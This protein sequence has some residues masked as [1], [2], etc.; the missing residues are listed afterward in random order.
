[1]SHSPKPPFHHSSGPRSAEV[2]L[3][4]EAFGHEEAK[5]GYPFVGASG[6]ELSRMLEEAGIERKRCFLTNVFAFQ[7]HANNLDT[8]CGSKKEV[9]GRDY[10][11]QPL[12]SG[13]YLQPE[14]FGELL[15]LK[16]ELEVV[17]PNLVI[18]LGSTAMW[19]LCS[20]AKISAVRGTVTAASLVPGLKVLPTY[21]PAAVLR[22]WAL[23]PIVVADLI[24]SVNEAKFPEIIR[25]ARFIQINPTFEEVI[26][27]TRWILKAASRVAA[28]V[29]TGNKQ[30]KCVGFAWSKSEALVVPFVDLA[31]PCGSYWP[32]P[33]EELLVWSC[34]GQILEARWIEKVFQ[35]GLYD[36]QYFARMGFKVYSAIHDTMLKHH[37]LFPEMPKSLGFIGSTQTNEPAWKLMVRNKGKVEVK[38]D[39]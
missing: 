27:K 4:G 12:A 34:M 3:V 30:I 18:A 25:P 17:Q 28:D 9:G 8:I 19:A 11:L 33:T 20:T 22:N 10:P 26:D 21:H 32:T 37:S 1:M 35:N 6:K 36:I 31:K 7:P 5:S 14:Y 29:E 24:K 15:R 39:D 16:E 23:R 2:V 38:R 13:K